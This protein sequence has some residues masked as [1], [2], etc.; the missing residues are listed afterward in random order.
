[1]RRRGRGRRPATIFRRVIKRG[2][3]GVPPGMGKGV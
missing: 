1:L 3:G 2:R